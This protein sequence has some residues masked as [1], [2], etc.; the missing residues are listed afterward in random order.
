MDQK[1]ITKW[2]DKLAA[3]LDE[4][5]VAAQ[6]EQLSDRLDAAGHLQDF[7]MNN[8]QSV[9]DQPE[10]AEF[11]EMDT[12]AREAHDGLLLGAITDRVA[13]IMKQTAELASLT[14]KVQ[15][16]TT[17]N[18]QAA[19]SIQ[20]EKAQRVVAAV[21]GTVQALKDLKTQIENQP[22]TDDGLADLAKK[23]GKVVE[24]LQDL[25]SDVEGTG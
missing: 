24:T 4:A 1:T 16:Q 23:I 6:S 17:A 10:T 22:I 25:R 2:R 18:Q 7:I 15:G 3:L 5:R 20:L 8:P 9:P 19:K 21:T 14:K 12:I 11:D 13:A